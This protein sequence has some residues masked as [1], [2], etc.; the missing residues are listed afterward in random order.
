MEKI[1]SH[2]NRIS[3]NPKYVTL[4]WKSKSKLERKRDE[5]RSNDSLFS[6]IIRLKLGKRLMKNQETT[7]RDVLQ[8]LHITI[9]AMQCVVK[10]WSML[11]SSF[12]S[13]TKEKTTNNKLV[14]QD[15]IR[16]TQSQFLLSEIDLCLSVSINSFAPQHIYVENCS[17]LTGAHHQQ[18][19]LLKTK[20][21]AYNCMKMGTRKER[22]IFSCGD[23]E[24]W[25]G[26]GGKKCYTL[27]ST[28]RKKSEMIMIR[29][30]ATKIQRKISTKGSN[31]C[32]LLYYKSV[33][34]R[35]AWWS[36]WNVCALCSETQSIKF[37]VVLVQR[38]KYLAVA[39]RC[40][41]ITWYFMCAHTHMNT[42]CTNTNEI[43]HLNMNKW[44]RFHF[45]RC[46]YSSSRSKA[47]F[48]RPFFHVCGNTVSA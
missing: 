5:G 48:L 4:E 31:I 2:H 12:D 40:V 23:R 35:T 28:N 21:C 7:F 10:P 13:K 15:Q 26:E 37:F 43:Y 47:I 22:Y 17:M 14:R 30:C 41:F 36:Y 18:Y 44:V 32:N 29:T 34:E 11:F 45:A 42:Q 20:W 33:C 39:I 19:R 8:R 6:S 46:M 3:F 25:T 24:N 1:Q 9:P 16:K 38:S 27:S